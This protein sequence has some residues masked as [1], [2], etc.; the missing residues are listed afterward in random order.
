MRNAKEI[1]IK[2]GLDRYHGI[3]NKIPAK[4]DPMCTE[5]EELNLD[6]IFQNKKEHE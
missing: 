2:S 3:K 5:E 4:K 6:G 1:K